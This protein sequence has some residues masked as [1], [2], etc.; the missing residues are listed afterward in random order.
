[1]STYDKLTG[2]LPPQSILQQRYLIGAGEHRA[3]HHAR[4]WIEGHALICLRDGTRCF[5]GFGDSRDG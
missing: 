1:M 4:Q 3:G 2:R 5:R